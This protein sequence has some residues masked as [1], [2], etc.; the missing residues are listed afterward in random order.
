MVFAG[1]K[2]AMDRWREAHRLGMQ[3][4][5]REIAGRYKGSMFG[6]LWSGLHPLMMLAIYTVFFTQVFQ[7]KWGGAGEDSGLGTYAMALFIGIL[8]HGMLAESMARG[9]AVI[10]ANPTFVKKIVFPLGVLPWSVVLSALF[11]YVVGMLLAIV[12]W[13]LLGHGPSPSLLLWPLLWL[14]LLLLCLGVANLTSA[15]NVYF[16]DTTQV[17]GVLATVLL[18]TSPVF[19]SA[20][21]AP[22]V[23]AKALVFNPLTYPME[24]A[25]DLVM[26]DR[27]M[28]WLKYARYTGGVAVFALLTGGFFRRVK[29]GFADVL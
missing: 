1:M 11:T 28:N 23:V 17:V 12:V 3:L 4:A 6:A 29:P 25:R 19:F 27:G 21:S 2:H 7:A 26:F 8:T 15:L 22:T 18:F 14:P 9:A 5:R 13:S 10:T 20:A 16:R 24:Q